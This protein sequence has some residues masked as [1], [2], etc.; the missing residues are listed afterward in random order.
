MTIPEKEAAE[1]GQIIL[2]GY[3]KIGPDTRRTLNDSL[4][5]ILRL[6]YLNGYEMIRK[7]DN[8]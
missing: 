8:A 5:A 1:I 7:Q 2:E 4:P 6:Y 3:R